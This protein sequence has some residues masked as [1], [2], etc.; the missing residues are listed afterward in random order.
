MNHPLLDKLW[1]CW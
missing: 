1:G